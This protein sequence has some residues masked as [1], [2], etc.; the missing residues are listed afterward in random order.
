MLNEHSASVTILVHYLHRWA[1]VD[2]IQA[3]TL[4]SL[5]IDIYGYF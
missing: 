4:L 3:W 2:I 5:V 1:E